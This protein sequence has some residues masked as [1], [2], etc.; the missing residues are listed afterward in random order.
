M[1]KLFLTLMAAGIAGTAMA[2]APAFV[3]AQADFD[4][5]ALNV[6]T[7]PASVT[8]TTGTGSARLGGFG[9]SGWNKK[10]SQAICLNEEFA[11]AYAGKEL[12]AIAFYTPGGKSNETLSV[13]PIDKA[14]LFLSHNLNGAPFYTKVVDLPETGYTPVSFDIDPYTFVAGEKVYIGYSLQTVENSVYIGFIPAESATRPTNTTSAMAQSAMIEVGEGDG[15]LDYEDTV[16][17]LAIGAV[18]TGEELPTGAV[19]TG[20]QIPDIVSPQKNSTAY[21][22]ITNLGGE[23]IRDAM[24]AYKIGDVE[25]TAIANTVQGTKN[26]RIE[27]NQRGWISF[28]IAVNTT[29]TGDVPVE[30]T[31][32]YT[33]SIENPFTT[34][35]TRKAS[36]LVVQKDD[37][38]PRS[39]VLEEGTGTWCGYC[40]AGIVMMEGL[41]EAYPDGEVIRIAVHNGD[42]MALN[43]YQGFINNYTP[44]LP[45]AYANRCVQIVP[46]DFS[47]VEQVKTAYEDCAAVGSP[48]GIDVEASTS[49][50]EKDYVLSVK[51]TPAYDFDNSADR[52]RIATVMVQ[53]GIG[54]YNQTNYFAGSGYWGKWGESGSTVSTMYDDVASRIDNFN[55][56]N[57]TLPTQLS[58]GVT[59]SYTAYS[60]VRGL[61]GDVVRGVVM[62]IDDITGYIVNAKVVEVSR[63]EGIEAVE[64]EPEAAAGAPVEYFNLQ[65]QR[66]LNPA[67]GIFI[68]RQG[69]EVS[70]VLV[71]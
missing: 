36:I 35:A 15:F 17:T 6:V 42:E 52:F 4:A 64:A 27:P 40:P 3:A 45:G 19:I 58:A 32:K 11:T 22:W 71:K 29:M 24:I 10:V 69:S 51:V 70:K 55:G 66:V 48:F 61:Y 47:N 63:T 43:P 62:L 18:I 65:G 2:G 46:N 44:G 21:V 12:T 49:V 39:L 34:T 57:N 38:F 23:V 1:K 56:A 31:V 67:N 5:P 28:P 60:A 54:P 25:D 13:N 16:G 30:F 59:V 53:D 37:A 33:N 50:D 9:Q 68:R 14:T 20:Y 41:K 26:G 7:D 8:I